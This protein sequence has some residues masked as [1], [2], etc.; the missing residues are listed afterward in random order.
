VLG[1]LSCSMITSEPFE[2]EGR[3]G[4]GIAGGSGVH[5]P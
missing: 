3:A 2:G 5:V 1:K 4:E